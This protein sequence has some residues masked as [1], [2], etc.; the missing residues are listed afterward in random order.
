MRIHADRVA[1]QGYLHCV[2]EAPTVFDVDDDGIVDVL[3]PEPPESD[4]RT[5]EAAVEACPARALRVGD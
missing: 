3:T 5:V 1:C 2:L 4:R